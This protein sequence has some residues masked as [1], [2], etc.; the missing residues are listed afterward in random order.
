MNVHH[1]D[2]YTFLSFFGFLVSNMRTE[3]ERVSQIGT[4]HFRVFGDDY[5]ILF[6]DSYVE[7]Y[8]KNLS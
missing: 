5:K 1:V 3:V 7:Q 2:V 4:S 8:I 6:Q